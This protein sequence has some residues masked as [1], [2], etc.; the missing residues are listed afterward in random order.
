MRRN[1]NDTL[2]IPPTLEAQ[3]VPGQTL[4]CQCP[5]YQIYVFGETYCD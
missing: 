4:N 5:E 1:Y 2:L 3:T